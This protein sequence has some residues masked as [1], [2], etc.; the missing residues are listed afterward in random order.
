MSCIPPVKNQLA[1]WSG[2]IA[3]TMCLGSL[4]YG[5]RLGTVGMWLVMSLVAYERAW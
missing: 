2:T 3:I 5:A 4:V 1:W